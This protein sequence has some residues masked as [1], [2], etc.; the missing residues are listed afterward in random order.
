MAEIIAFV[1]K[2][3]DLIYIGIVI[4]LVLIISGQCSKIKNMDNELTRQANNLIAATEELTNYK[5]ELGRANAEKHAYQLTQKELR[6]S[7]GL[8][9]QKNKEYL[10]YINT[11]MGIKDTVKVETVIVKEIEIGSQI[12]DGAITF[13][14]SDVFGKSSRTL[15]G[16]IP[17]KVNDNTLY[18]GSATVALDQDI[19]VEGWLEKNTKTK[20]T[21][22]HLRSDYPGVTFNSGMGI[23]AQPSKKYERDMRK[24]SG[25]GLAVGPSLGL[26]Y[27]LSHKKLAPTVGVSITVGY[28]YTPK[29][30]QW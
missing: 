23:V 27:D 16:N 18:T 12:A 30:F 10:S 28:T 6:D 9:K 24:S 22:I 5:D 3:K 26:G 17:Y 13:K 7:V 21:F 8:L 19:F 11:H 15:S 4:L 29:I 14:K 1:K 25:I 20:E 2:Y